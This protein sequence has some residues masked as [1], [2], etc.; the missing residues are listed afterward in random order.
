MGMFLAS[1]YNVL[2]IRLPVKKTLLGRSEC[3]FCNHTLRPVDIIPILG[4]VINKGRCHFC[5]ERISI[6]YLIVEI[7]GGFSFVLGYYM[8]G[9]SWQYAVYLLFFSILLIEALIDMEKKIIL[10]RIWIFGLVPLV[11]LRI[12]QGEFFVYLLSSAILF[13][14]MFLIS[15]TAQKIMKRE[16]LGGGDVKLYIF[17]GFALTWILGF[18]SIFLASLFGFFYGITKKSKS[19]KEIPFVPFIGIGA[20]VSF[21]YGNMMIDLYLDLLRM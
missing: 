4:Y 18:L 10:D 17:I 3:P 11:V 7:I 2:A 1:F 9:Y 13:T 19:N 8:F 15:W 6:R 5:S 21:L 14:T 12:F 16:A 20:I